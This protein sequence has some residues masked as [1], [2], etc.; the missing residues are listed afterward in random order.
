MTEWWHVFVLAATI[1]LL[2]GTAC[3]CVAT[4]RGF[5]LQS[6][7]LAAWFTSAGIFLL[8]LWINA[9]MQ[10]EPLRKIIGFTGMYLLGIMLYSTPAV[11][12]ALVAARITRAL[13]CRRRD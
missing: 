1:D 5:R 4:W 12:V 9:V 13:Q 11:L 7:L 2:V 3:G 6:M 10:D 8:L